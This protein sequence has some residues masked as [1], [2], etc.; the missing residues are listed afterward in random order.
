M[1]E[2]VVWS[3]IAY[4]MTNIVVYGSIFNG[5][6]EMI[7]KWSEG[8]YLF[9]GFATFL[10]NMTACPMCFNM[11]WIFLWNFLIFTGTRITWSYKN[12]FMVL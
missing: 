5:P 7:R 8:E 10:K 3:L 6:R 1:T 12:C 4:G 2:L 9:N 11:D